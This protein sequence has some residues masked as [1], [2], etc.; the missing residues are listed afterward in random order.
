MRYILLLVVLTGCSKTFT[1]E[2]K[3]H[4]GHAYVESVNAALEI[5]S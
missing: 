4:T 3:G 5:E 1:Y 2:F